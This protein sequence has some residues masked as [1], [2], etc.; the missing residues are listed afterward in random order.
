MIKIHAFA[1]NIFKRYRGDKYMKTTVKREF[2][3]NMDEKEAFYLGA[4]VKGFKNE[5]E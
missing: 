2:G 5:K 3:K 1:Q 4:K